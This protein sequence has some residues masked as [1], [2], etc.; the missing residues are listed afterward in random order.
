MLRRT[1]TGTFE[2]CTVRRCQ[3][4]PTLG[5]VSMHL[6]RKGIWHVYVVV[7][8]QPAFMCLLYD[9]LHLCVYYRTA[10]V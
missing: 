9:S 1:G 2:E 6:M 3:Q 4:G 8:W 10:S 5:L 7:I